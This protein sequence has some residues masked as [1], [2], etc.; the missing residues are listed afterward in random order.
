[1][2]TVTMTI[3]GKS[4]SVRGEGDGV[5]LT[6]LWIL[7]KAGAVSIAMHSELTHALGNSR[8][9]QD[10]FRQMKEILPELSAESLI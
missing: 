4:A 5:I 9:D 6:T 7:R 2:R 10:A 3:N 8:S 1:M